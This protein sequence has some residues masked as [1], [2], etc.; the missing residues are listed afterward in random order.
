MSNPR[1]TPVF[2][3]ELHGEVRGQP[4]SHWD[5]WFCLV[6][7]LDHDGDL[8]ALEDVLVAELK[9]GNTARSAGEAKLSDRQDLRSRLVA[10]RLTPVDL[11]TADLLTDKALVAKARKKLRDRHLDGRAKTPVM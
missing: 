5:V 7:V 3:P 10:A 4:W 8:A 11:I 6:T 1:A 9:P 2:G